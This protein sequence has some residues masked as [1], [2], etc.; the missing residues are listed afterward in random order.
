MLLVK[1]LFLSFCL[2]FSFTVDFKVVASGK[3]FVGYGFLL[4][5]VKLFLRGV[6]ATANTDF[7]LGSGDVGQQFTL[8][9]I[10]LRHNTPH[11]SLSSHDCLFVFVRVPTGSFLC[12]QRGLTVIIPFLYHR[13]L[14]LLLRLNARFVVNSLRF[15]LL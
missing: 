6:A 12:V 13:G 15:L 11:Q 10:V 7:M 2:Q 5:I 14:V 9:F 1:S 4:C 8:L 3:N